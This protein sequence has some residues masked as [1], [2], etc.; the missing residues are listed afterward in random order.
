MSDM[1]LSIYGYLFRARQGQFDLDAMVANFTS[2]GDETVIAALAV[3]EDD[4]LDRLLKYEDTLEGRLKVV[5][6]N[7]DI[8]KNN[9]F[10]GDLKTAAMQACTHP[11]R[12][13][14]DA[15]ER[16]IL[17]QRPRW[18]DL[19][20]RLLD[21]PH[22]DGWLLPVV[23]CYSHP[24][25]IREDQ[26]LGLKFRLHK[27]TV[28][29]RGVPSFAEKGNGLFSTEQSDSTEPLRVDGSLASFLCP[30]DRSLLHPSICRL[31][32]KECYVIH[33]GFLDLNRRAELGRT[34]WKSHWEKRSGATEN[35]AT[36]VSDLMGVNL[37]KH[38]LPLH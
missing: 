1:K 19:A 22:L 35:V 20:R 5:V 26:P 8:E 23:D 18:D 21:S 10:D 36:R 16:L 7:M 15:D 12:A 37:V 27:T 14:M 17:S 28:A 13:I 29:R 32:E 33:T 4:T 31:L 2:F 24:D 11:I 3:Q 30:Y 9:R 38:N 34:F 6:V 25:Y